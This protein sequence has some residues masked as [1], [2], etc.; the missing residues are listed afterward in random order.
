MW[1]WNS[2][3]KESDRLLFYHI[4][5]TSLTTVGALS[6][7][8]CFHFH[9]W[10]SQ[11]FS[12]YLSSWTIVQN[13]HDTLDLETCCRFGFSLRKSACLSIVRVSNTAKIT[14]P[15][16]QMKHA[17]RNDQPFFAHK[18]Q[19][20]RRPAQP[21]GMTHHGFTWFDTLTVEVTSRVSPSRS[22]CNL[23]TTQQNK[24]KC[25]KWCT[26]FA[27]SSEEKRMQKVY[28][29][30]TRAD[31]TESRPRPTR[32]RQFSGWTL[33]PN[34][35]FS[36][37]RATGHRLRDLQAVWKMPLIIM[38]KH[39]FFSLPFY[40]CHGCRRRAKQ[41]PEVSI[42]SPQTPGTGEI[43]LYLLSHKVTVKVW[44]RESTQ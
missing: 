11:V 2:D 30:V 6:P 43:T 14:E 10:F 7:G 33:G 25:A 9:P 40:F 37:A 35:S 34:F 16:K 1:N 22:R 23:V 32:T 13:Q 36:A 12:L 27:L 20:Q 26:V 29:Q 15:M 38:L 44:W 31:A 28:W 41:S 21:A 39:F 24:L 8:K 19:R 5:N 42:I 3:W 18:L 4:S 17:D